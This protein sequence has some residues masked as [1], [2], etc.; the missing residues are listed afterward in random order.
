MF[1]RSKQYGSAHRRTRGI[2]LIE[3]AAATVIIGLA[4]TALIRLTMTTTIQNS[5]SQKLSA[6]IMLAE[7]IR[8]MMAGLSF[9]DPGYGVTTF[10][11]EGAETLAT[12]NDVDDFNGFDS[13]NRPD[14][15]IGSPIGVIDANRKVITETVGEVQQVPN[16]WLNW[17]QQ[18]TVTPVKATDLTTVETTL[19]NRAVVRIE[20]VVSHRENGAWVPITNLRWL[21]AR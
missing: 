7:N 5:A 8:E 19:T 17:R 18:I 2:T 9:N 16:E 14:L 13:Q 12:Y 4:C 1:F 21:K 11:P 6:G 3:T 10:G 15:P 20:V